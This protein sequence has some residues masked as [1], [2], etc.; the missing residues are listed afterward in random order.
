M[1]EQKKGE[2]DVDLLNENQPKLLMYRGQKH[3]R[4]REGTPRRSDP[5]DSCFQF[6]FGGIRRAVPAP[7]ANAPKG[8]AIPANGTASASKARPASFIPPT[9]TAEMVAS[10]TAGC[11]D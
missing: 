9:F 10:F 5:M 3:R 6:R 11:T 8:G 1:I 2:E 4:M 7:T